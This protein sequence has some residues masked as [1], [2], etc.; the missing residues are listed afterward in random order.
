MIQTIR[1]GV[2]G[3]YGRKN[4]STYAI[5]EIGG[6]YG[7]HGYGSTAREAIEDTY[8]A[9][10]EMKALARERGDEF[11]SLKLRFV[12]DVGSMFSYYSYLNMSAVAAKMG[13]NASL[14]RKYAAGICKPSQK[15]LAAMQQCI[16]TISEELNAVSLG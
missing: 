14:L 12:F 16:K 7:L 6:K 9:M 11:P 3:D 4:F 1:M 10:D 15:R 2:E 5:D 13:I 8:A